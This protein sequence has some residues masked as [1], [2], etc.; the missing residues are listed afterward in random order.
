MFLLVLI[1]LLLMMTVMVL[2]VHAM[3][4][5]ALL[6]LVLVVLLPM[7]AVIVVLLTLSI[8]NHAIQRSG[9]MI[10]WVQAEPMH[11]TLQPLYTLVPCVSEF[12]MLAM[13]SELIV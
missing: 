1:V 6:V 11:P 10:T 12:G 9:L 8:A 3:L 4:L 13:R 7:W 2:L 5:A